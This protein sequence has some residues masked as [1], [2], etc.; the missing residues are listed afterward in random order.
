MK[1]QYSVPP[2]R[3]QINPQDIARSAL[4]DQRQA[5]LGLLD[6]TIG[7][8][9][10]GVLQMAVDQAV[11]DVDYWQQQLAATEDPQ[12][13]PIADDLFRLST[14]LQR[15]SLDGAIIGKLMITL[16]EE[17]SQAASEGTGR[18][19]ADRLQPLA[20]VLQTEGQNLA[21]GGS[22]PSDLSNRRRQQH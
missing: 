8:L 9:R 12:L 22:F 18:Q 10:E 6:S 20:E 11:K 4:S 19:V 15:D 1:F 17:V 3:V 16:S 14:E 7:R 2:G 13:V 5:D 21:E